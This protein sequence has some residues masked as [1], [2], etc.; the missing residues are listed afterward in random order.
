MDEKL[1]V[2]V[3]GWRN[4]S[5]RLTDDETSLIRK[6]KMLQYLAVLLTLDTTSLT[7]VNAI[8]I[9]VVMAHLFLPSKKCDGCRRTV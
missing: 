6:K 9:Y 3:V 7:M 8:N 2:V 1:L 4:S 5:I